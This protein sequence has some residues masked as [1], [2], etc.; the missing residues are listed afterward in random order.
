MGKK[1]INYL[2]NTISVDPGWNTG[3]AYWD[4]DEYP[5]TYIIEEPR[6]QKTKKDQLRLWYMFKLFENYI[7]NEY[8]PNSII[9]EGVELWTGS[10][11]S[12]TSATRG[13][14]FSL[15][16][17]VGGYVAIACK[18]S[19]D[20]RFVYA[21]GAKAKGN[22]AEKET[23]KG[24]LNASALDKRIYRINGEKYPEHI[25]EAVGMGFHCMGIL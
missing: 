15:A 8:S 1:E 7:A 4:G 20:V 19:I 6:F 24:Q 11:V 22:K 16:Y 18:Y 2:E 12:M 14:L 25:R 21:R 3:L 5:D 17:L 13:D 9:I 23:W 10:S